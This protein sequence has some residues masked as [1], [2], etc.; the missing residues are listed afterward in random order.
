MK[1]ITGSLFDLSADAICITTNGFVNAQGANTMGKG[2]AGEAKYRW[3]GIQM[4]L[5]EQI[6]KDGNHVFLLTE[7]GDMG[8]ILL[9]VPDAFKPLIVAG[10]RSVQIA[11]ILSYHLISFPTKEHWRD[12]SILKLIERSAEE[13]L[14]LAAAF[15][16]TN[17]L[18]PRPGCGAGQLSWDDVRPVLDGILDDRFV[19]VTFG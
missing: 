4:L 1:E 13:L 5:G 7:P 19:A 11:H 14:G 2:C 15:N 6:R 17:V 8:H 10:D 12:P 3:P 18:I 16:F 9:D